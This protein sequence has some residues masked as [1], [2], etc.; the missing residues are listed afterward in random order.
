MVSNWYH[1]NVEREIGG[2]VSK[3]GGWVSTYPKKK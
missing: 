3:G 1:S 2:T